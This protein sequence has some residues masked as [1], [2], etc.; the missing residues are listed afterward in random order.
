MALRASLGRP[1]DR[2]LTFETKHP[3][4]LIRGPMKLIGS[5]HLHLVGHLVKG[6]N[7]GGRLGGIAI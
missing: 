3:C 2:V 1:T 5:P 6:E 4:P 7:V